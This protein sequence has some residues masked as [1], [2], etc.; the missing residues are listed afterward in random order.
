M[1]RARDLGRGRAQPLDAVYSRLGDTYK[2]F[3]D[4]LG[5]LISQAT[6]RLKG[7]V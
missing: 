6:A 4:P 2:G 3:A 7:K 1:A 5:I